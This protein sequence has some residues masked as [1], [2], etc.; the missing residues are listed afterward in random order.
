MGGDSPNVPG[1]ATGIDEKQSDYVEGFINEVITFPNSTISG[2]NPTIPGTTPYS[3]PGST[4]TTLI[5]PWITQFIPIL[6]DNIADQMKDTANTDGK[7]LDELANVATD[8]N[9]IG[10]ALLNTI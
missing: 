5:P 7:M 8:P 3:I 2:D 6:S 4:G 10:P 1:G 9:Q